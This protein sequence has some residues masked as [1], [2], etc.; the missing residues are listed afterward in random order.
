MKALISTIRV[1]QMKQLKP[2]LVGPE[3][4]PRYPHNYVVGTSHVTFLKD[5]FQ[6]YLANL[7]IFDI[8][9]AEV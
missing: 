3:K 1:S 9:I 4:F 7:I 2:V 6:S 5:E 8:I